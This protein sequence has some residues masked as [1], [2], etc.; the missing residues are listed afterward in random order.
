MDTTQREFRVRASQLGQIMTES[1]KAG[2]LSQTAKSVVLMQWLAD[3]YDYEERVYSDA[4]RKGIEL[5][6]DAIRLWSEAINDGHRRVNSD[7]RRTLGQQVY[8]T[9]DY[10]HGTPDVLLPDCVEDVKCSMNLRTFFTAELTKDYEYQ[11]RAYMWLTGVQSARLVY[12]MMPDP[13]WMVQRKLYQLSYMVPEDRLDAEQELIMK[14]NAIINSMHPCE[15]VRVFTVQHDESII[16]RVIQRV[17]DC[18]TYYKSLDNDIQ[19]THETLL[20]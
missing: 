16:Q 15:R 7:W 4:M 1:R 13:D 19:G 10:V 3:R 18:R 11:L 8:Y 6:D 17:E 9:N 20:H 12:V 5:E 14:H 2:E